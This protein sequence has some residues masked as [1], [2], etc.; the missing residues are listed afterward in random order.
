MSK[1][2]PHICPYCGASQVRGSSCPDCGGLQDEESRQ[3]TA[4][5]L[6]PWFKRDTERPFFLGCSMARM[7]WMIRTGHV[8]RRS[9]IRGPTTEGFWKQA[10]RV[11]GIA[12]LFGVCHSCGERVHPKQKVCAVCQSSLFIQPPV[13]NE[14]PIIPSADQPV[15]SEE[16]SISAS[17][18][19]VSRAQYR[20]IERLQNTIR[21]QII[22]LALTISLLCACV[23]IIIFFMNRRVVDLPEQPV[24][25]SD[26]SGQMDF[27]RLSQQ[28]AGESGLRTLRP[29]AVY[30]DESPSATNAEVT[31]RNNEAQET[32]P[33][34]PAS[35]YGDEVLEE[36]LEVMRDVTPAQ[37]TLLRQLRIQMDRAED[38][39]ATI[40][41]RI[42]AIGRA[43]QLIDDFLPT[44][45]DDFF[46]ARLT[47]LRSEFGKVE[48][49]ILTGAV[50]PPS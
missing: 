39:D 33:V 7:A 13:L 46:R 32:T 30:E 29:N 37:Q 3:A 14:S 23:F 44:E 43:R 40:G 16:D 28:Q 9:I 49:Q 47:V 48:Q 21:F 41:K 38:R 25:E 35:E 10:D 17:I 27:D 22:L 12:H 4:A 2:S 20:R 6:G 15:S 42:D 31:Y 19:L 34:E 18:S 26:S 8:T 36:I 45:T 1:S 24:V 50:T 5:E 11:P